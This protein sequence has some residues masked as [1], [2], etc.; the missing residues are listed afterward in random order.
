MDGVSAPTAPQSENAKGHDK[1]A[2][3]RWLRPLLVAASYLVLMVIIGV[4]TVQLLNQQRTAEA[5]ARQYFEALAAGNAS[6]ANALTATS[7]SAAADSPFLT[8]E[9]LAAATERISD[10]EVVPA[11]DPLD[12]FDQSVIVSFTLAD[13]TYKER[14]TLSRGEAEW[15]VLRTWQM[16]HPFATSTTFS[17]KGPGTIT[18]AGIP[19]NPDSSAGSADLFPAVYPL[20]VLESKWVGLPDDG[21][22]IGV[23]GTLID[24]TLE[25]TDE[26][27]AE[28]QRQ[29]DE[30]LDDCVT[31]LVFPSGN[32]DSGCEL[33]A[34]GSFEGRPPG[35]WEIISYPVASPMLGG[36]VYAYEGGEMR[37]TPGNGGEPAT[38]LR[39]VDIGRFV[40]VTEDSV[41]LLT[42]PPMPTE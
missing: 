3:R 38:A 6:T 22:T 8:D 20:E 39:G 36:A 5:T 12:V 26:L 23:D 41:T 31:G 10:V 34:L 24:F 33:T 40:E 29:M 37:F 30:F 27:T 16:P 28:V 4:V 1:G 14:V 11:D 17:V 32:R 7:G 9:V 15:G 35:L 18:I 2:R 25:P 42:E 19:V 13:K 21:V